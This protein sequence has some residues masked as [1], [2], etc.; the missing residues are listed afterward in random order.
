M[1]LPASNVSIIATHLVLLLFY[2]PPGALVYSYGHRKNNIGIKK[3]SVRILIQSVVKVKECVCRSDHKISMPLFK[4]VHLR[5]C[6][7]CV[8][9]YDTDTGYNDLYP[10]RTVCVNVAALQILPTDSVLSTF[11]ETYLVLGISNLSKHIF[12]SKHVKLSY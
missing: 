1:H 9:I 3:W 5:L 12:L 6:L 4:W 8:N 7:T 10:N 2:F 11:W